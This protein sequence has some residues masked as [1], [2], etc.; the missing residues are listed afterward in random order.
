MADLQARLAQRTA[1]VKGIVNYSLMPRRDSELSRKAERYKTQAGGNERW[2]WSC[3]KHNVC[4]L[5]SAWMILHSDIPS[6]FRKS[7]GL[8]GSYTV[9]IKIDIK[10]LPITKLNTRNTR[11][12][13]LFCW[14]LKWF[15]NLLCFILY[16]ETITHSKTLIHYR[17]VYIY[18]TVSS[19]YFVI[20]FIL[21][22][23]E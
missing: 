14:L 6:A 7:Y 20:Y 2:R 17:I 5:I 11:F 21:I 10:R 12:F 23:N 16:P 19:S 9:D 4:L 18:D 15:Q 8:R 22:I 3:G 13:V 1:A